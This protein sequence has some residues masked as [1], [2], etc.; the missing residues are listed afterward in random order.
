MALLDALTKKSFGLSRFKKKK[1]AEEESKKLPTKEVKKEEKALSP[2]AVRVD[3]SAEGGERVAQVILR[4]R[5]TEKSSYITEDNAYTFDVK[6]SANKSEVKKAIQE[7]Y[8][9]TPR[10]VRIITIPRKIITVRNK[11]G[12]KSGGKKAV[13][14]L[15]DGDRIEFV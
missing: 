6:P 1:K 9:V 10:K 4:P 12:M 5:I 2:G 14:Y 13:V 3:E 8:S 11:P 15:N 7:I